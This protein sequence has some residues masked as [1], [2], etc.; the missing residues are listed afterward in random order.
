MEQRLI[1]NSVNDPATG[2]WLW[3]A[4]RDRRAS[5]PYGKINTRRP[6]GRCLMKQAHR[7]SYE[8]FVGPIP[9]GHEID[10]TCRNG[11]CIN[12]AHLEAVPPATNKARRVYKHTAKSDAY[13]GL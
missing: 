9:E 3:I 12:P 7:V 5:T 10:H 4:A 6:D 8:T 2:C 1:V 11:Y 13:V